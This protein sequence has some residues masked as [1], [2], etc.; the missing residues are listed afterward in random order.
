MRFCFLQCHSS[1]VLQLYLP[2]SPLRTAST[3]EI[4]RYLLPLFAFAALV[5]VERAAAA[6]TLRHHDG[7]GQRRYIRYGD[8]FVER[9]RADVPMLVRSVTLH[10]TKHPEMPDGTLD[11]R[12]RILG[13]SGGDVHPIERI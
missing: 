5:G 4:M 12:L 1:T 9:F 8:M 13:G 10:L 3:P 11:F 6:A 7:T 2:Q